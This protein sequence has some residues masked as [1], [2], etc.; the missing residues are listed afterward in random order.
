MLFTLATALAILPL[1]VSATPTPAPDAAGTKI[2][3]SRRSFLRN[4]VVNVE[5]LQGHVADVQA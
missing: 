1:L 2:P 5:K 4:G 3:L